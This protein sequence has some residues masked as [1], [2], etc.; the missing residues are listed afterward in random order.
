MGCS[1]ISCFSEVIAVPSLTSIPL[2]DEL[3]GQLQADAA[4]AAGYQDSCHSESLQ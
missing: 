3:F 2:M 4:V 1:P